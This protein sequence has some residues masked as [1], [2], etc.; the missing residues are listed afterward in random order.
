MI[1]QSNNDEKKK[2]IQIIKTNF[3]KNFIEKLG[4]E[5]LFNET[6]IIFVQVW[7]NDTLIKH[8]INSSKRLQIQL[9]FMQ[10]ALEKEILEKFESYLFIN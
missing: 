1:L 7:K 6:Y 5:K 10:M 8:A 9:Q 2:V 4:K 3:I